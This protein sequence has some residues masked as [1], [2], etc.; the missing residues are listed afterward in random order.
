MMSR[1]DGERQ[2]TCL[3][4][5]IR[6][7]HECVDK[8]RVSGTVAE[9]K[10]RADRLHGMHRNDIR[11]VMMWLVDSD[12]T[13]ILRACLGCWNTERGTWRREEEVARV[14]KHCKQVREK[15]NSTLDKTLMLW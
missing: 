4:V 2:D 14:Y 6:S 15:N 11:K 13:A 3:S 9:L 7:W 12:E 8:G 10:E 1:W 5:F